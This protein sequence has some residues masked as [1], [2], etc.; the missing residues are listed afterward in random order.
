MA[1][2][3]I[4]AAT[5]LAVSLVEAKAHLRIDVSDDDTLLT[6]MITAATE[7]AEQATG[8]AIMPQ[9]WEL[10]LDEFPAALELTRVPVASITSVIYADL[11]GVDQT[12]SALLYS[13]DNYDDFGPAYVVPAYDT[14]WPD[15]RDQINAVKVRYVAG[16]ANAAAVPESIKSWIK[17]QV[18]AMY[19][20]REQE[21]VA[22]GHSVPLGF[23]DRLLDRYKVWA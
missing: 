17:L 3:L 6:A 14:E 9:T 10:T 5:A 21:T 18:G 13:L 11:D 1:L 20:N 7:A 4:T 15:T 23:A 8:R 12:L 2:K 16:Y 22:S 19:E